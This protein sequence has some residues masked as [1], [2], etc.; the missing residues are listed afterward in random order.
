MKAREAAQR[1]KKF[2]A[3]EK[4]RKV[5]ELE[6]MIY[7]FDQM[8]NEL[9][10]QVEAEEERTGI[11]DSA[12]FAYSTFARSAAQRREN[13]LVSLA[14]LQAQL[15]VAMAARDEAYAEIEDADPVRQRTRS[16]DI[17]D[18]TGLSRSAS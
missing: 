13:L 5:A 9:A 1:L 10:R 17:V 8:A 2:E 6:Q 11:H 18:G 3:E 16:S 15:E 12:H 4:G 14:S 7:E